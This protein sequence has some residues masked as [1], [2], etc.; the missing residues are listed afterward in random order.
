[1]RI[2]AMVC[3]LLCAVAKAGVDDY[4]SADVAWASARARP[5]FY[6]FAAL[7]TQNWAQLDAKSHCSDKSPGTLVRLVF[8]MGADGRIAD[9]YADNDSDNAKCFQAA[10]LGLQLTKPPFSPLPTKMVMRATPFPRPGAYG[11]QANK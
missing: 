3:L 2:A 11:P 10:Y 1:M 6:P 8:M 4:K 7:D 9:V 5:D